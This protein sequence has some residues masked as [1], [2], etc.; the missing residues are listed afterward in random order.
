MCATYYE[1]NKNLLKLTI[2][3]VPYLIKYELL[4]NFSV[5]QSILHKN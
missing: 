3:C 2:L 4:V 1:K 5:T